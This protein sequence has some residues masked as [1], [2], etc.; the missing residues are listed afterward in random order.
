M[1]TWL[2]LRGR[3]SNGT[4]QDER[5]QSNL[6]TSAQ[7]QPARVVGEWV[8]AL[9]V[10]LTM[11]W[12]VTFHLGS[13][14][15]GSGDGE[16]YLWQGWRLGR[17][18]LSTDMLRLRIPDVVYPYG[19][20]LRLNDGLLPS[21]IGGLWNWVAPPILAYNLALLTA[22]LLNY[23]AARRLA[24]LFSERRL[25]W[26]LTGLAFATAPPIALRMYGHYTL[27]FA[28]T[29]PLLVGEAVRLTRRADVRPLR[30]GLLLFAAYL[31]SI[32]YLVFGG[33]AFLVIAGPTLITR[34]P[35]LRTFLRMATTGVILLVL[36]LPF[37]IPR[38][39]LDRLEQ[40]AGSPPVGIAGSGLFSADVLSLVAQPST[41]TVEFPMSKPLSSRF[42]ANLIEAATFPGY[43]L[44]SALAGVF[45]VMAG[46]RRRLVVAAGVIWV[47]CLGSVLQVAGRT[48]YDSGGPE[49]GWLPFD[50]LLRVPGLGSMRTPNR[51]AF[52]LA[53][54]LAA[55]LAL[56]LEGILT[57][58]RR[59]SHRVLLCA[60][61]GLSLLTN[62]IVPMN[63]ADFDTTPTLKRALLQVAARS[64]SG[65]T[66]LSVP[67]DCYLGVSERLVKFQ[68][69]HRSPVVGCQTG[70]SA[71]AWYSNFDRYALSR[72]LAALRCV[73][74]V[75]GRR[76]TPFTSPVPLQSANLDQAFAELGVRF[77]IVDKQLLRSE[78]QCKFLATEEALLRSFPL[79]GED[80]R[81]FVIDTQAAATAEADGGSK[82]ERQ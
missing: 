10:A 37:V 74:S 1:A 17:M 19:A 51:A 2:G 35:R 71:V 43:L 7:S 24:K 14:M 36:L 16:Y 44:L 69:F 5:S 3:H 56:S 68:V 6:R 40:A 46:L 64:Q 12:P 63:Y 81:W 54:V 23:W 29:A 31:C 15:V 75:I 38:L 30:L 60:A 9:G 34:R 4:S 47:F 72:S 13:R 33:I 67:A 76:A 59:R 79:L 32:Y 8:I 27:Y 22:T 11:M 80:A 66:V 45:V 77:L 18:L 25:V 70:T 48:V 53:A 82:S 73:P 65:E 57:R 39:R 20:D 78:P 52:T 42:R 26:L 58:L 62:L 55:A 28:F 50:L 41:A 61:A 21:I 49:V